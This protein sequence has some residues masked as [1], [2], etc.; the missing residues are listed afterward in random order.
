[1]GKRLKQGGKGKKEENM[2]NARYF[3]EFGGGGWSQKKSAANLISES[4]SDPRLKNMK[5]L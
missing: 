4:A 1:M 5:G 2:Q 3:Y